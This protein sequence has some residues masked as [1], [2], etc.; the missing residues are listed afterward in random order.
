MSK[1]QFPMLMQVLRELLRTHGIRH[2]DIAER[3]NISERTVSRWLSSDKIEA[4]QIEQLCGLLNMTLFDVCELAAQRGDDRVARLTVRQEQELVEDDLLIYTFRQVLRG[5]TAEEMRD[6]LQIPEPVLV[7]ALI[8]LEKLGL[9][10]L[11]PHNQVRLRT[12][13][14]IAWL[15][16][17][18]FTKSINQWLRGSLGDI[19]FNEPRAVLS[20]DEL[21]LSQA[22]CAQLRPKLDEV[23]REARELS[24]IDRRLN[25]ADT[26][27]YVCIMA[28]RPSK[29][30]PFPQWPTP[31][32]GWPIP[33]RAASKPA[34]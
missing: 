19:D 29:I 10:E 6:D 11:L 1:P 26:D 5:W 9:I 13:K 3:L 25:P 31:S 34:S 33:R 14:N 8:R 28:I 12:V 21:K 18:P 2:R 22:S 17:G 20:F 27:W 32:S 23:I 16:R 7:D 24:E 30:Q 4:S 15:P